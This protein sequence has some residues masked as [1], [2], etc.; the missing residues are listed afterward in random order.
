MH[1]KSNTLHGRHIT[2]FFT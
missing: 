1:K 2:V